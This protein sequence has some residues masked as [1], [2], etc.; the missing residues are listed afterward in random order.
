MRRLYHANDLQAIKDYWNFCH[1]EPKGFLQPAFQ[2]NSKNI[3]FF[4][5]SV[6][7]HAYL[8]HI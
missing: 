7:H 5:F 1:P 8:R 4:S 6:M 3:N 2:K